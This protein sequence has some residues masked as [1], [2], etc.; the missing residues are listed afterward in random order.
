MKKWKKKK[1]KK[2]RLLVKM[3]LNKTM[4][5]IKYYNYH[6]KWNFLFHKQPNAKQQERESRGMKLM[7]MQIRR[8]ID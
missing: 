5:R 6:F 2:P 1:N 3:E 7:K 4:A 8:M